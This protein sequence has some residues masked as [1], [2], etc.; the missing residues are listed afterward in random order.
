MFPPLLDAIFATTGMFSMFIIHTT[1]KAFCKPDVNRDAIVWVANCWNCFLA[2]ADRI[3][4]L[5]HQNCRFDDEMYS[6]AISVK[7]LAIENLRAVTLEVNNRNIW[8]RVKR[9]GA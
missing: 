4:Q 7:K 8:T 3:N 1:L 9:D 5:S 6:C 2:S